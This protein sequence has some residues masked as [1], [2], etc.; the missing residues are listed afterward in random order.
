MKLLVAFSTLLALGLGSNLR[1]DELK[2]AQFKEQ[3]GKQ[4]QTRSDIQDIFKIVIP[5][6]YFTFFQS[7]HGTS[8]EIGSTNDSNHIYRI[9]LGFIEICEILFL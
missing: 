1:Y 2:F 3:F 8:F 6:R 9:W 4:Y 7:E 5:I